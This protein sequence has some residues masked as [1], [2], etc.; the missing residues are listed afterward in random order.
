[1]SKIQASILIV[2]DDPAIL[3]TARLFLK[4]KFEF[5]HVLKG[6]DAIMK[7]LSETSFD[8]V[9]LDMNY[10][11]GEID[12]IR[13]LELIDK[14]VR[15]Y[16]GIDIIPI[17]AYGEIDL[18]VEA[19]KRGARD[20]ITKP[21]QNERLFSAINNMLLLRQSEVEVTNDQQENTHPSTGDEHF[22]IGQSKAFKTLL[23]QINKVAPTDANVL[24]LGETGTGKSKAAYEIHRL[25]KRSNGPFISL[26]LGSLPESL[27]ESELFGSVKGAFTDSKED[28][29]GKLELANGGTL[30]LDE[31]GNISLAQQAKLLSVLEQRAISKLGSHKIIPLDIRIISATNKDLNMIISGGGFRQDFLYRINTIEISLPNLSERM[32]DIPLLVKRFLERFKKKYDK[33]SLKISPDALN[34]I[35]EQQ[36]PGNIRQLMHLLEKTVIMS[37]G[38]YI[39]PADLE[40]SA[41]DITNAG[42]NIENMEKGLILK[43]L[44]KNKG[45]MTHAAR[46]LGIDRQALYRRLDKYG[47]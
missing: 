13:G 14:I 45:N 31:I 11:P 2:D 17:T 27:F 29:T 5:V 42:L 36:W 10:S 23:N 30:F 25:S 8:I 37:R 20:F 26:D 44:E 39:S 47:L 40:L 18:A 9:L 35:G 12:G 28:K 41:P 24:I 1:M 33:K 7:I 3:T 16:S 19:L 22:F 15:S 6:P 21:W 4:Q 32:E 46:D 34:L 43:A 38:N